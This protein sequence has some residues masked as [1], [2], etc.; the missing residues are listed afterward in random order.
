LRNG[1]ATKAPRSSQLD[2]GWSKALLLLGS[3]KINRLAIKMTS[4]IFFSFPALLQ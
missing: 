2:P 4:R 1:S 3:A